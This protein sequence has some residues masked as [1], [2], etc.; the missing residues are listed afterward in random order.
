MNKDNK[1]MP[2]MYITCSGRLGILYDGKA[3]VHSLEEW[4]ARGMANQYQ[5]QIPPPEVNLSQKG[6]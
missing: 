3:V 1:P 6:W 4:F 2:V 5:G